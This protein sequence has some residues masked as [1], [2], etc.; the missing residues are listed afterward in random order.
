M[1]NIKDDNVFEKIFVKAKEK[2]ESWTIISVI[3]I[4]L[5]RIEALRKMCKDICLYF[6][7][8]Y[9][10][11]DLNVIKKLYLGLETIFRVIIILFLTLKLLDWIVNTIWERWLK[12]QTGKGR[13]EESLF[14]YLHAAKVSHCFLITG[15]WGTGKTYDVQTFLNKYYRHSKTNVYRISCFELDSREALEKEISKTIEQSDT[16]FS[17]VYN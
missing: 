13:F 12:K 2:V 11:I 8:W 1:D 9:V 14:R 7:T 10:D 16:S 17:C 4:L 6:A 3:G 15:E 5:Y